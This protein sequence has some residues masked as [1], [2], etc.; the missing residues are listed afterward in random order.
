MGDVTMEEM[1]DFEE[2]AKKTAKTDL[3]EMVVDMDKDTV[4]ECLREIDNVTLGMALSGASGAVCVYVLKLL[5][6]RL[7]RC[8][9]EDICLYDSA[10][11]EE[12]DEAQRRMKALLER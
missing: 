2:L 11:M 3:L 4:L 9:Y 5:G 8:V 6:K 1:V 12:V 7:V 10:D